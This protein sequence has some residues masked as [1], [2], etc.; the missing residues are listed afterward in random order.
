MED[1]KQKEIEYFNKS[2]VKKRKSAL[3]FMNSYKFFYSLLEKYSSGKTILDYGCGN[4]IHS[5]YPIER[6]AEKVIGI[7]LSEKSLEVARERLKCAGLESKVEFLP[8]DCEKMSFPDDSFDVILD[9]GTFSSLDLNDA[10]PE[11]ARVLRP[12]GVI[13]GIETFGHN[14]LTNFKRKLNKI[15]GKRTGWGESHIFNKSYLRMAENYFGETKANYFHLISWAAF[16]FLN[17]PGGKF[18]LNLLEFFE[19]PLLK[20]PFFKKY[21]FKTVFEFKKPIKK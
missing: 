15:R 9:G 10:F 4:G 17:F 14:P 8:M 11:L 21:A 2:G 18:L 20:I 19:K 6:G 3:L 12:G 5:F 13:L 1:R 7:D 16:P